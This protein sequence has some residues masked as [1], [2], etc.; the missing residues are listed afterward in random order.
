[1][2]PVSIESKAC[3][4]TIDFLSDPGSKINCSH[5]F[6]SINCLSHDFYRNLDC[7]RLRI[8]LDLIRV[9]IVRVVE[10]VDQDLHQFHLRRSR[11]LLERVFPR[12]AQERV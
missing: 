1:M 11:V 5:H 4:I 2:L 10:G 9:R 7:G 12:T 8:G 3:I 6:P